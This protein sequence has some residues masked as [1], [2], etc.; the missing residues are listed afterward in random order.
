[1]IRRWG[2]DNRHSNI[3]VITSNRKGFESND[4][5]HAQRDN[6][7]EKRTKNIAGQD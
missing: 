3:K 1:M 5:N 4:D 6:P 2:N 7:Y